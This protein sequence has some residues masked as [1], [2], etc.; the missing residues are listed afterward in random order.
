MKINFKGGKAK[1][2]AE[3]FFKGFLSNVKAE[4]FFT[5]WNAK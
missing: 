3:K 2:I 1:K 4:M 5:L